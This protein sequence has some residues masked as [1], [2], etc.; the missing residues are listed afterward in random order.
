MVVPSLLVL[1][2]EGEALVCLKCE[3]ERE[4]TVLCGL[5]GC[6]LYQH[7]PAHTTHTHTHPCSRQE[8]LC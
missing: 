1:P 4:V 6:A 2:A 3:W 5:C 8:V 7:T